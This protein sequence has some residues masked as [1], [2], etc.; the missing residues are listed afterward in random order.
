MLPLN[1]VCQS[2]RQAECELVDMNYF[3]VMTLAVV[4]DPNRERVVS[5]RNGMPTMLMLMMHRKNAIFLNFLVLFRTPGIYHPYDLPKTQEKKW[6]DMH[7]S[8][9]RSI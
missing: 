8:H 5:Q 2:C 1:L 4:D 3:V 6:T 9:G 7:S